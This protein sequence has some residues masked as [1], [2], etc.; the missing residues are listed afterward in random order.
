MR[1]LVGIDDAAAGGELVDLLERAGHAVSW[2]AALEAGSLSG[3]RVPD[4]VLVDGEAPM[5]DLS[6]MGAAWRRVKPSPLFVVLAASAA[7][8]IAAERIGA[9]VVPKPYSPAALAEEVTRLG[10]A[11]RG[12]TAPTAAQA[13]R[14]LGLAAGGLPEDEAATILAGARH[15]DLAVVR[16]ALRP[17]VNEYLTATARLDAMCARRALTD[18]EAR[19]ALN[20]DGAETL[21]RQIDAG[22]LDA[23]AA[24]RLIWAL[25][26]GGVAMLSREPPDDH[27][28][29]RARRVASA[30]DDLRARRARISRASWYEV[31]ELDADA[32]PTEVE[33]AAQALAIRYAPD[34]LEALDLGDLRPLVEPIWQQILKARATLVDPAARRAYDEQRMMLE[35]DADEQRMRRRIDAQEAE[36]AFV[37][38]Q[39]ALLAGDAFKAV[40]ELAAAARRLPDEPDY[41]VYAAWARCCAE[42]ARG[43]DV[44]AAAAREYA[45]AERALAGRRPRP[46]ALFALGLLAESA[47]D[48]AAAR[49]HLT[50]ALACDPRLTPA[51]QLLARLG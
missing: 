42:R 20:L 7:A 5:L 36:A 8:R 24:A 48:V 27:G 35:P 1:I 51:R 3:G 45:V 14:L 40:S 28:H 39:R 32:G 4:V 9:T 18:A 49:Q 31:L 2:V 23:S 16:E 22:V 15:I 17:H 34:Q 19:F 50:E 43:Q 13:L 44:P 21:R 46:R 12:A 26:C 6:V 33:R 38:G 10:A 30:R 25:V 29:P 47:G 37:R 11:P 41:E